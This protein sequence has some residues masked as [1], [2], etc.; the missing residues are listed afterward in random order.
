MGRKTHAKETAVLD[1]A[2]ITTSPVSL[3]TD[4]T[5]ADKILYVVD[6]T[7]TGIN[8]SLVF[9]ISDDKNDDNSWVALDFGQALSVNVDNSSHQILITEV[10]FKYIR[11]RLD[12][13][14]GTGNITATYRASSTGA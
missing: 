14:A 6:W 3:I 5:T 12:Y 7:S 13:L 1:N 2:D 9:E 8:G 10:A 11:L 4:T